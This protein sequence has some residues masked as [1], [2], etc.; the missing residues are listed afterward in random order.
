MSKVIFLDIDGT[1]LK[2]HG[3]LSEQIKRSPVLLPGVLEK[4][5]EWDRKGYK[6]ILTTGRRE[7]LRTK[8][9]EQLESVGLFFDQLI[10]NLG[11]GDRVLINDAKPD[12]DFISTAFSFSPERNNG[13]S[14]IEV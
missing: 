5:E 10:M 2:H 3:S 13:I 6:I 12:K 14:H 7:H 4:F 1:I 9:I 8:T 11:N